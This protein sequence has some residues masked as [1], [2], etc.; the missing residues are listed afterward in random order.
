MCGYCRCMRASCHCMPSGGYRYRPE[1]GWD[2]NEWGHNEHLWH[3]QVCGCERGHC[4]CGTYANRSTF[5]STTNASHNMFIDTVAETPFEPMPEQMKIHVV[6]DAFTNMSYQSLKMMDV[7]LKTANAKRFVIATQHHPYN[8]FC[9]G[10]D[11]IVI[12]DRFKIIQN[13]LRTMTLASIST[14]EHILAYKISECR[15]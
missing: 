8:T 5:S 12:L 13:L 14:V 15:D 4:S 1:L 3:Q 10:F 11:G 9:N 2:T 7:I 6:Q